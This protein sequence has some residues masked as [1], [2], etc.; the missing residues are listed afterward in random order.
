MS[1]TY[2]AW[3]PNQDRLL[4]PSPRDRFADGDLVYFVLEVVQ[5][6]DLSAITR[7]YEKEDRGFPKI[8]LV[9]KGCPP[10]DVTVNQFMARKLRTKKGRET[11][12]KLKWMIEPIFGQ[13]KHARGFRQSLLR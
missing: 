2:R 11:Y 10:K 5:V 13:I 12:V 8:P 9:P 7:K 3:N 6:L 1:K 4:P